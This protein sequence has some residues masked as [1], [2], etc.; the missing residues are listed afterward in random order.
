MSVAV[1]AVI[2]VLSKVEGRP[3]DVPHRPQ[4]LIVL[5]PLADGPRAVEMPYH[6]PPTDAGAPGHPKIP[7]HRL[8]EQEPLI[9]LPVPVAPPRDSSLVVVP[10]A[11]VTPDRIGPGFGDGQLWVR[12][13]PLPPQELAQRLQKTNAQ[14]AD[15]VVKAT[16]QKFLDSIAAEPGADGAQLPDWSANIAGKKFGINQ[17]YV[18]VAGLK[19]PAAVLALLPL[20]GGT[21]ESK[22]FDHTD[23]MLADLRFAANRSQTVDE[24]KNA[25]TEMRKRKQ[26]EHEF[27]KNQRRA[28]APEL[29]S[30][31]PAPAVTRAT[32]PDSTNAGAQP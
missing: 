2:I 11:S 12:P 1:H 6:T 8:P 27:Q 15:S 19:I 4:Q 31:E 20:H 14:L 5:P 29:R 13:L 3:P 18:T 25:I 7:Q 9:S 22:A 21:N 32:P 30:P 23:E 17:K 28:P 16:I 10:P 24:F 26:A